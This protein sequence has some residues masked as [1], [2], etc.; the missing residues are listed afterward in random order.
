MGQWVASKYE[1]STRRMLDSIVTKYGNEHTG[2]TSTYTSLMEGIMRYFSKANRNKSQAT[3]LSGS[4]KR[5][6]N[7]ICEQ[8]ATES[9]VNPRAHSMRIKSTQSGA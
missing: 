3:K 4:P 7:W 8:S 1:R 2:E 6:V 5:I 9:N